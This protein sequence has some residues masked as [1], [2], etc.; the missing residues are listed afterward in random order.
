MKREYWIILA[1][2]AVLLA[3]AL[4]AWLLVKPKPTPPSPPVPPP[5]KDAVLR[6][7]LASTGHSIEAQSAQAGAALTAQPQSSAQLQKWYSKSTTGGITLAVEDGQLFWTVV[8]TSIVLGT[9]PAVF[10]IHNGQLV[11]DNKFVTVT[12]A[13]LTLALQSSANSQLLIQQWAPP[14]VP[15]GPMPN[16]K[17]RISLA[18][19]GESITVNSNADLILAPQSTS[20][21]Q[22]FEFE[23]NSSQFVQVRLYGSKKYWSLEKKPAAGTAI[24]I[25]GQSPATFVYQRTASGYGRLQETSSGLYVT[26]TPSSVTLEPSQSTEQLLLIQAWS[27]PIIPIG[28]VPTKT[29]LR[30]VDMISLDS[31][32]SRHNGDVLLKPQSTSSSQK[33]TLV[34][35]DEAA[36][37]QQGS[38]G[39]FARPNNKGYLELGARTKL[40][41]RLLSKSGGYALQDN[42]TKRYL[43]TDQSGRLM[44]GGTYGT[45][46]IFTIAPFGPPIQPIGPMPP[47]PPPPPTPPIP[48]NPLP[49]PLLSQSIITVTA[50]GKRL[51]ISQGRLIQAENAMHLWQMESAPGGFLILDFATGWGLVKKSNEFGTSRT[52]GSGDLFRLVPFAAAFYIEHVASGTW[53]SATS[54]KIKAASRSSA[55]AFFITAPGQPLP[56]INPQPDP[57]IPINPQPLPVLSQYVLTM[58]STGEPLGFINGKLGQGLNTKHL[59]QVMPA[60]GSA[61]GILILDNSSGLGLVK[62]RDVFVP[63]RKPLTGDAFRLVPFAGAFTVQHLASGKWLGFSDSSSGPRPDVL[64]AVG[65]SQAEPIFITKPG[66]PLPIINPFPTPP[67]PPPPPP[68]PAPPV[69]INPL[70]VV[71]LQTVVFTNRSNGLRLGIS[72]GSLIQA[73]SGHQWQLYPQASG[74]AVR[75]L[76]LSTLTGIVKKKN[77]FSTGSTQFDGD[78]FQFVPFGAAFWVRHVASGL[79]IGGSKQTIQAVPR[80]Q[81]SAWFITGPDQPLPIINPFPVP[82]NPPTPPVPINK[83]QYTLWATN[84]KL[85]LTAYTVQSLPTVQGTKTASKWIFETGRAGDPQSFYL[86]SPKLGYAVAYSHSKQRFYMDKLSKA[87]LFKLESAGTGLRIV[88]LSSGQALRI[89]N[90]GTPTLSTNGSVFDIKN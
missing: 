60:P 37:L 2:V 62:A 36:D 50:N 30:I 79:W 45:V 22:Q 18:S 7:S 34:G 13:G 47:P 88:Q 29:N 40:G 24:G 6:I 26:A 67:T 25:S 1:V 70:P 69:P 42:E 65:A 41:F 83:E 82:P 80:N 54:T 56:I 77:G 19:T 28:P 78:L 76:D 55:S 53:L 27:G 71:L 64:N 46:R 59:F 5:P 66:Q 4:T 87:T 11:T 31:V 63:S 72:R 10:A 48:I 44:L 43:T 20:S 49:V 33:W 90:D 15:I 3:G 17:T 81:A 23:I 85:Y 73:Q 57:P 68:P 86:Y 21:A 35:S 39:K 75:I 89:Q 51:G 8:N 32:D 52:V 38:S 9:K 12:A 58:R 14:I 61:N 74:D 84:S 16:Q